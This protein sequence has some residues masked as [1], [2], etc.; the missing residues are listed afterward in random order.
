M[1]FDSLQNKLTKIIRNVQGKGKFTEKNMEDTLKEI[2]V[3]LL[4]A[5]VNYNVVKDFLSKVSQE[6][7]GREVLTSVEPGEELVKIVHDE[8]INLLGEEEALNLNNKPAVIM[9]VGL[10]GTGKT[11]QAAKIANYLKNK[12][13]KKPLLVAAD[14]IRP[15]A[16]E[17]LQKLGKDIDVEVFSKGTE[18]NPLM[19]SILAKEYAI[20][21][22]YDTIIIDTAG[23]LQI[24]EEL[25]EELL[26]LKWELQPDEILLTVDAMTGQDIV[27]VAKSFN[28]K[29]AVTGL[30]V[31]KFDADTRGGGVLSVKAV[32]GVPVKFTGVGE[33]IEDLEQFHPE[34]LADRILGM[35]DIV[36]LVEKAQEQIDME[37][38]E[39]DAKKLLSGRFTMD[40]LLKQIEQSQKIGP[41]ANI[42]KMIPGMGD[43]SQMLE[44]ADADKQLIKTKAMIQSMTKAEREDP[45]IIMSS[46]K[47]RIANGSGCTT[48]DVNKL[49]NQYEKT[50]KMMKQLSSMKGLFGL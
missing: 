32:T 47:R 24:N 29:L 37:E 26:G 21:N 50:K 38:A 14:V 8:I 34:R 39:K 46:R 33:K 27:N 30:I 15:A 7:M 49:L 45:S 20:S 19:T 40:D 1:A 16:I 22:G 48:S 31:T 4:E 42:A 36:S 9:L 44:N 18:T 12:E 10:Q 3:A 17:Q 13:N 11:T 23:R 25:M 41:I 28:D 43:Y 5:D 6:I 35:G 2:R